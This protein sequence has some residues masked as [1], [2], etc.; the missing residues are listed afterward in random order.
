MKKYI[1]LGLSLMFSSLAIAQTTSEKIEADFVKYT[2]LIIDKKIDEA[3]EFT[4]PKLFEIFTKSQMKS[5]LGR[6]YNMP[7]IE[8]KM[9]LPTNI[10]VGDIIRIDNID[11]AKM[12]ITSPIE[13][14]FKDLKVTSENIIV[15]KAN[16]EIT[17]GEGNVSYDEKT[18][19]FKITANKKIIASS[20]DNGENWKF[21][22]VD[23]PEMEDILKKIIPAELFE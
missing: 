8:Y 12:D 18:N 4:N 9:N 16:F 17:F 15:F 7:N 10:K 5:L 2:N 19:F 11:Y 22:L 6:V 20:T 14:K 3:I 21:V 13:M 1:L 23:N